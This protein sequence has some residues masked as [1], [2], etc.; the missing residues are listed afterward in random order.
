MTSVENKLLL[1]ENEGN[2]LD[3]AYERQGSTI[4]VYS[5]NKVIHS[6]AENK[7]TM[8]YTKYPTATIDDPERMVV[9]YDTETGVNTLAALEID[10]E[11]PSSTGTWPI[12]RRI[13]YSGGA[14]WIVEIPVQYDA[15]YARIAT[16]LDFVVQAMVPG[17]LTVT[18][19]TS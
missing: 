13:P 1:L 9:T 5:S 7:I 6:T 15:N 3:V 14:Q 16:V 4:P 2:A 11:N 12:W 8:T 10:V 17:T 18:D 19:A